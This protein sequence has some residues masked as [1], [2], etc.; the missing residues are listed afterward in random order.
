MI[1][2]ATATLIGLAFAA[3]PCDGRY[4]SKRAHVPLKPI[5]RPSAL[6]RAANDGPQAS[7]YYPAM[8][9]GQ[10]INVQPLWNWPQPWLSADSVLH[11]PLLLDVD[12]TPFTAWN[13][14]IA[15]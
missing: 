12:R 8:I 6:E 3:A 13:K 11:W 2:L 15:Q 9:P 1:R 4:R 14:R 7:I 5:E 10:G